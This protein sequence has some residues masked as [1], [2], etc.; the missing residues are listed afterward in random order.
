MWNIWRSFGQKLQKICNFSW[1]K[2]IFA[3]FRES[4]KVMLFSHIFAQNCSKIQDQ[5]P[6]R[7]GSKKHGKKT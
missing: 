1:G 7:S 2:H 6:L 4:M 3:H 5:L